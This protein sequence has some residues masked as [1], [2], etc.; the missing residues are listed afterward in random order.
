MALKLWRLD[1]IDHE[2]ND[3]YL[4]H[5]H[6]YADGHI[7]IAENESQAR[8][9]IDDKRMPGVWEN[10]EHSTCK[11]IDMTTP[12]YLTCDYQVH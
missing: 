5:C 12:T 2:F 9:M 7:V 1:M 11:E 3:A 4:D 6:N 10:P 8:A